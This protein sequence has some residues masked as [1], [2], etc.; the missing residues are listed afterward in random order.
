MET[1]IPDVQA[2]DD[3]ILDRPAALDDSPAHE[4]YVAFAA[5]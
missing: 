4:R 3:G 2:I 1:A 5:S